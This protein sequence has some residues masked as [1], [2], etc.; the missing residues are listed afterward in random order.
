MKSLTT[1]K[2]IA[3]AEQKVEAGLLPEV[4]DDYLKIVLAGMKVALKDGTNGILAGL[5]KKEDP[6][7]DCAVGAINL[8]MMLK[9]EA[10][11]GMPENAMVPASMTLML[12]ALEFADKAG[13][14]KVGEEELNKATRIWTNYLLKASGVTP[15]ML[16]K[17]AGRVQGVMNDPT[18]MEAIARR[19][20]TVRDP[21]A[22]VPTDIIGGAK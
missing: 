16:S 7:N 21:R 19:A 14:I 18:Q 5:K 20:G 15:Q 11:G 12:Q 1:N 9:R 3:A 4:R 6:L 10:K 8:V 2:V 22:G 17:A 13:I